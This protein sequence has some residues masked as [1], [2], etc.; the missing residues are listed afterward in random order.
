MF[1]INDDYSIYVTRGDMCCFNVTTQKNGKPYTF[2]V[3]EVIRFNVC[4]KKNCDKVVLS[5]DFPITAVTQNV[6]IFLDGNDTK[7]GK[8]ISKPTDYWYEVVL[9]PFDEPQTIIGYDE[10]GTRVFRLY[11][12][13]NDS[14]SP[15]PDP[16]VIKV[17]DTELDMTSERPI[18][19]QAIAR[20]F[21]N[22]QA[23]YQETHKAVAALHV[24]PQMFGAIGDGVSDDTEAMQRMFDF[25]GQN[26]ITINI[27]KGTYIVY[28]LTLPAGVTVNGNGSTF[29]KPNLSAEP[30][31]MTVSE[32]K[33]VRLLSVSYSGDTDSDM[34]TVKNLCFD[35]NCWE[36]WSVE[37]GYAQE[38]AS[39]LIL[40][41]DHAKKGRLNV[42]VE[43][44]VFRDSCSDGVHVVEN[45]NAT[46]RNCKS[47]DCFRGGLVIT[48]GYTNVNVD[49]FEFNSDK[50]N[51]GIDIEV[52]SVGYENSKEYIV[53]LKN[54]VIDKDLDLGV[55]STGRVNIENLV[56]RKG[57]YIIICSGELSIKN[58]KLLIDE[59][60][61]TGNSSNMIYI[62]KYANIHFDNV[63]FDGQGS[64]HAA[65]RT[66][67]YDHVKS[68]TTFSGCRFINGVWGI[69]GS[70]VKTEA[71]MIVNNCVFETDNGFGGNCD[72]T[73]M[74][75]PT[76]K[77]TNNVFN[78]PTIAIRCSATSANP[79]TLELSGNTVKTCDCGMYIHAPTLIMHD[80]VWESGLAIMYSNGHSNAKYFGKRT[81]IVTS[82]P[83]GFA[84][85]GGKHFEDYA[86]DGT[87]VWKFSSGTTW[88]AV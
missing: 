60:N 41:G 78:V 77:L 73:P 13:A 82:N 66:I 12:E 70:T 69:S 48:G 15:D 87:N 35:G 68:V 72:N 83:N 23:G 37:D 29:K 19:N 59:A 45:T 43:N 88:T 20:A 22:L 52:D 79:S 3:G 44:C 85:I 74:I 76:V 30:Y 71:T 11:P 42:V 67:Y 1:K 7:F 32:M 84:G 81:N 86:T 4:E 9:N 10:E 65:C 36:M 27:P 54:I 2:Q 26:N 14:T 25:A 56:M 75:V 46:I 49:G 5:K 64:E 47:Y 34:T 39:L 28:G 80:E 17:I 51:D 38:Q 40:S 21:A 31:N 33:W 55:L 6:Q 18:Q 16:E 63:L 57:G 61:Y 8:V 53:S 24:T 62:C 50:V 58:A